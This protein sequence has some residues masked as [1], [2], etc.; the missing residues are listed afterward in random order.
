MP[1]HA[2]AVRWI[3]LSLVGLALALRPRRPARRDEVRAEPQRQLLPPAHGALGERPDPRGPRAFDGWFPYFAL[4]SSFFHHY[5]SLPHTITAFLADAFGA[6]DQTI[7]LWI[8]YLLLALWPISVYLGARLLDWE[9]VDGGGS[10]RR[11]RRCSSARP[12]YGYEHGSY[13]WQGYGVYSQLWAMWLLPIA[14]GLTWRAVSRGRHY[15][16]AAAALALTMA[17]HFI[18]GYLAVLTVGVWV[19]VV[20]G[21]RSSAASVAPRV[22]VGGAVL[23]AAWVL[24]P[25]V[26]DTKWTAQSE[27]YKGTIFN[28]SYGAPKILGWLF[29]GQIFDGKRF[30]IITLLFFAGVIV[31]AVRA[32]RRTRARARCSAPSR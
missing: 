25:L 26:G 13:T 11:S 27:Y 23:I 17:C 5:Q 20:G 3:P 28:D 31:C 30:P 2:H 19:I 24:V 9:H 8:L 18:T 6:G 32:P 22:A 1:S 7:Y 15:A 29:T 12:G 16:A 4:G 10:G 21:G 14:W